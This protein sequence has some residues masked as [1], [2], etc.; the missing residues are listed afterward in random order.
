LPDP[1]DDKPRFGANDFPPGSPEALAHYGAQLAEEMRADPGI[2]ERTVFA[3]A[4]AIGCMA[5]AAARL[6]KD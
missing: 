3:A 4:L 6:R 1:A 2:S 5:A